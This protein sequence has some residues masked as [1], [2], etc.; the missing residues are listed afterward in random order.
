MPAD[1]RP[2]TSEGFSRRKL[3]TATLNRLLKEVGRRCGI[4][5]PITTHMARHS[6]TYHLDRN[7]VP[8]QRISDTLAH[9]DLKTTQAYVKKIRSRKVD[10][11]LTSILARPA[12]S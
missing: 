1:I 3:V 6:W 11:E 7:N 2:E 12:G 4:Q 8:V 10:D 5:T 9:V